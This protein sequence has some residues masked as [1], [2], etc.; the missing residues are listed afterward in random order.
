MRLEKIRAVAGVG[1]AG[2]ILGCILGVTFSAIKSAH[3]EPPPVIAGPVRELHVP[4]LKG[5]IVLDGD[6]DDPGWEADIARTGAFVDETGGDARPYS[7]ARLVW[8]DGHLYLA[9][10]AADEDIRATHTEPDGPVWMDDS[11][12]LVFRSGSHE[13]TFDVSPL[14]I[15]TDGQRS[16]GGALEYRW[17]SGAHVSH[18]LDGTMN[19]S[20][21]DDEE[22][23]IEMAIPF[24]ALGI[25][26]EK[27]ERV[28]LTLGRCD[29]PHRGPRVCAA[30]ARAG[31]G[32]L[33][34]D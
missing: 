22:W 11:F 3:S 7:D 9:L 5:S 10:Y 6:M 17:Q 32:V 16:L 23:V 27:G 21:D 1:L 15:L 2:A 13:R 25:R 28:G 12:H 14:G 29:S 4:H 31:D 19:H 24:R 18:E 8:G 34:L 20:S 33:V 30:W 26:G